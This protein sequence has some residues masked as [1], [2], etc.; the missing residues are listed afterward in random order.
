LK[1]VLS[2][3]VSGVAVNVQN[4]HVRLKEEDRENVVFYC[5]GLES[6]SRID[7][8]KDGVYLKRRIDTIQPAITADPSKTV[9]AYSMQGIYWCEAWTPGCLQK[10][11]S[12]KVNLT[13]ER[14]I[15]VHLRMKQKSGD[16]L[17]DTEVATK[18]NKRFQVCGTERSIGSD[19]RRGYTNFTDMMIATYNFYMYV[20][21]D[22]LVGIICSVKCLIIAIG[23]GGGLF[24]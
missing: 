20:Q 11:S 5:E 8:I 6:K 1:P 4:G 7:W 24:Q 23:D 3:K 16:I 9:N 22:N 18:V 13:F 15:T 10:F 14:I 17:S 19:V 21:D 12:N 2:V